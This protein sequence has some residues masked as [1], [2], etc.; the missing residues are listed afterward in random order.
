MNVDKFPPY[1]SLPLQDLFRLVGKQGDRIALKELIE[2]RSVF[3]HRSSRNLVLHEYLSVR[4][5]D[6]RYH[7]PELSDE[8]LDHAVDLTIDKFTSLPNGS[9]MMVV[10]TSP[11]QVRRKEVDCRNYYLAFVRLWDSLKHPA[12]VLE[13]EQQAASLFQ[14]L[15]DRHLTFSLREARRSTNPLVS[16][17][18]WSIDGKGS[19]TVSLPRVLGAGERRR[20]L[21]DHIPDPDPQRPGEKER[22]Q[23]LID[24]LLPVPYLVEMEDIDNLSVGEVTP[25]EVAV[26]WEEGGVDFVNMVACEKAASW[27]LQRPAIATRGKEAVRFMVSTIL[28]NRLT[29]AMSD[30]QL[31]YQ[32][33]LSKATYSRFA[34]TRR[35]GAEGEEIA[36]LWRNVAHLL[37]SHKIF[38]EVAQ[39]VGIWREAEACIKAETKPRLRLCDHAR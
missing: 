21:E 19:L 9:G 30:E 5:R 24:S 23:T 39:E 8:V 20:W 18:R 10:G 26:Q 28:K 1:R 15:V 34:G 12:S 36:D 29:Q 17:Y 38:R 22:V 14:R 13:A 37:A 4:Q 25:F 32:F 7:H 3:R 27:E 11:P 35:C 2:H 16:R 33:G 31:A 6:L